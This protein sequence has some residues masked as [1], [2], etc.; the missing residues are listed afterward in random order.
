MEALQEMLKKEG[1]ETGTNYEIH[2]FHEHW[3]KSL[4]SLLFQWAPKKLS[5]SHETE[6]AFTRG[7]AIGAISEAVSSIEIFESLLC[8]MD[9]IVSLISGRLVRER[10]GPVT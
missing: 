7:T 8:L 4:P 3:F 2:H 1:L 9:V 5:I 10:I 6:S